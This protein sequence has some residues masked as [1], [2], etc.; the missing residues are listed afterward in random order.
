MYENAKQTIKLAISTYLD[1]DNKVSAALCNYYYADF[2][3]DNF[4]IIDAQ[5]AYMAAIDHYL[6]I[7]LFDT[8]KDCICKLIAI[9]FPDTIT[10]LLSRYIPIFSANKKYPYIVGMHHILLNT[11][12][13]M[14]CYKDAIG[15][16]YE[17]FV[18]YRKYK[19]EV[20]CEQLFCVIIIAGLLVGDDTTYAIQLYNDM[21]QPVHNTLQCPIHYSVPHP[22]MVNLITACTNGD[23]TCID[24][25]ITND[26]NIGDARIQCLLRILRYKYNRSAD[27]EYL[28]FMKNGSDVYTIRCTS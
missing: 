20:M 1:N 5:H 18:L 24:R 13:D 7:E 25:I 16:L 19:N 28:I 10:L 22:V 26:I 9:S 8:A 6:N 14:A 15:T 3:V 23:I 4:N 11:Y 2:L 12:L 17:L 21:T 27:A